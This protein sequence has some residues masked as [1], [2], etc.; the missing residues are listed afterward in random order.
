MQSKS[1]L[2]LVFAIYFLL[3]AL[4]FYL[5]RNS[6]PSGY[7]V[8]LYESTPPLTWVLLVGGIVLGLGIIVHQALTRSKGNLWLAGF[9]LLILSNFMVVALPALRGYFAWWMGDPMAHFGIIK[10][11][12]SLGDI[13]QTNTYPVTHVFVAQVISITGIS[14]ITVV[15]YFPAFVSVL[16]MLYIYLLGTVIL[17]E[18]GQRL[19]VAA[20][21]ATMLFGIFQG[22][23][24]PHALAHI[25][26]VLIIYLY[27]KSS[28]SPALGYSVPFLFL[29]VVHPLVH[30]HSALILALFLMSMELIKEVHR[31]I[32]R[33]TTGA[34]SLP[35]GQ[36]RPSPAILSAVV[37]FVWFSSFVVFGRQLRT[38]FNVLMGIATESP[39]V[40]KAQEFVQLDIRSLIEYALKSFGP[41]MVYFGLSMIA[42]VI[43]LIW[44]SRGKMRLGVTS[45][46]IVWCFVGELAA[47]FL[48][49]THQTGYITRA[50]MMDNWIFLTPVFVGFIL[51]EAAVRLP[52]RRIFQI[53][54]PVIIITLT[55]LTSDYGFHRSP[56]VFQIN[57]QIT[58]AE[59]QGTEW[60][61][62][63][64]AKGKRFAGLGFHD[65]L[66]YMILGF[67]DAIKEPDVWTSMDRIVTYYETDIPAHFGYPDVFGEELAD[68]QYVIITERFRAALTEPKLQES[69]V[70]VP[71]LTRFPWE[72][73]MADME[74]LKEDPT[75]N[76]LYSAGAMS[77]YYIIPV[78]A[79]YAR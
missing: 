50:L 3:M 16:Y 43:I 71:Q 69:R 74:R 65:S 28:R 52:W 27:F 76:E 17:E 61:L 51:Y 35:L 21:S 38:I 30:S 42:A 29:L 75:V 19:M 37:L 18:R 32:S 2:K 4:V 58:Y 36:A 56:W 45:Y 26:L 53:A 11:V 40:Q 31:R 79:W 39:Y 13:G 6:A 70:V 34:P 22:T 68:E 14:E 62:S 63:H 12:V 1:T 15:R 5:L 66:P 8:S 59:A 33:K 60:L 73:D 48:F 54:V 55:S 77:V 78:R 24:Y 23:V 20:A 7:E 10:D 25:H 67:Q 9:F 46:L 44:V 72:F 41:Q 49:W 57:N 47:V 64:Q